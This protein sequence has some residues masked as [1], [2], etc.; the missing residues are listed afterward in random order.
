MLT[1]LSRVI[2]KRRNSDER[3]TAGYIDFFGIA[4]VCHEAN[5]ALCSIPDF[6]VHNE[7]KLC[8]M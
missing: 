7:V 6:F 8:K 3:I 4:K 2:Q 5:R 1:L